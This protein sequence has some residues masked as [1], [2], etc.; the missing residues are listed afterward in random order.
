MEADPGGVVTEVREWVE[1]EEQKERQRAADWERFRKEQ[2]WDKTD[3]DELLRK[4]L[5][6]AR[7]TPEG[8]V[9]LIGICGRLIFEKLER[10]RATK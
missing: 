5:R 6:E 8:T 4:I 10:W 1:R 2:G 3:P 7:A 9:R